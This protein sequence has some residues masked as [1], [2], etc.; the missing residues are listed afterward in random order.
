MRQWLWIS[1][2]FVE[3]QGFYLCFIHLGTKFSLPSAPPNPHTQTDIKLIRKLLQVIFKEWKDGY[4]HLE[5]CSLKIIPWTRVLLKSSIITKK[6]VKHPCFLQKD[7][8]YFIFFK[9]ICLNIITLQVH[10]VRDRWQKQLSR[11]QGCTLLTWRNPHLVQTYALKS[12]VPVE[13]LT[14]YYQSR[15]FNSM[16]VLFHKITGLN[17]ILAVKNKLLEVKQKMVY[18]Q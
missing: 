10:R 2:H 13:P 1:C 8:N 18:Y 11:N 5:I 14:K 7:F 3:V 12:Q 9:M 15:N 6:P 17:F 4:R 16:R